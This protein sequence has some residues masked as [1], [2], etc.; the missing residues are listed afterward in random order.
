MSPESLIRSIHEFL[1]TSQ[2]AAV[3]E[4]GASIFDLAQSKY[5]I[6]GEHNK[7]LLHLWSSERNIVRRVLDVETDNEV[8]RLTVQRLGQPKPTKLEICRQ[9]DHRTPSA[10]RIA[11]LA[12]RRMLE[13]ALQ[14]RF[15]TWKLSALS[16]SMDLERSFG[17]I[18]ARGILRQ[19]QSAFAVLGL[20]N[21][22]AQ[23]S[24]D[25]ALTFGVLWLDTCRQSQS[26]K[27]VVEGLKLFLPAGSSMLTRLR[28]VHLNAEL[29]KWHL[30]EFDEREDNLKQIDVSDCGN[31]ATRLVQCPDESG[32]MARF[33]EPIAYIRSLMP[34]AETAVLSPAEIAFRRHGLEFA[35]TRLAHDSATLRS[36]PEIVFG[37]SREETILTDTNRAR[38]NQLV[39][40]IGEVRHREGPRDHPLWR[41][42]PER[43]LE[44]LTVQDV[45]SLDERLNAGAVYSQVPAFSASD[46][47][48]IDVLTVTNQGRLVVLELKADEDIHLPLQ[49]LDY[50]SRVSWHHAR[51]EFHK[52]GYFPNQE[53]C[54]DSPLLLLVAPAFHIHPASDT[55]L[56]YLS[57][58]I[59]WTFLGIDEHWRDRVRV[60]FRKHRSQT[61]ST[62]TGQLAQ[63]G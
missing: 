63:T 53:L 3:I 32:V 43:W 49:G 46:R 18:Y 8:L 21:E 7:C 59:E 6:S 36:T 12:Y 31:I 1:A 14:R 47:A 41:M 35:R 55:L 22:E 45:S 26:G 25:A 39:S 2:E 37:L 16:T 48:M 40:S 27:F 34:E 17:P 10:K 11:R 20:N 4:D 50:W 52:Y 61:S 58:A 38:F 24:V 51:G 60:V 54:A 23:A 19:G 44:S 30:Y 62:R 5:S 29:A 57:T 42:H 33:A 28:M 13:R 15:P 9:R 56:R